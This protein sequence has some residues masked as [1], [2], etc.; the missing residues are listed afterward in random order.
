MIASESFEPIWLVPHVTLVVGTLHN[1]DNRSEMAKTVEDNNVH[2]V[3]AKAA[4]LQ[5]NSY[6]Q[7][8]DEH[9]IEPGL[10]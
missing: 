3:Y 5:T 1:T 10:T 2:Y 7:V 8:P 6:C 4:T 9:P